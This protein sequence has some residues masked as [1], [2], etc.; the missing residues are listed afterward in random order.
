MAY[1]ELEMMDLE[2]ENLRNAKYK[3]VLLYVINME[4]EF[5]F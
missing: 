1:S 4:L 3:S 2:L 5:M